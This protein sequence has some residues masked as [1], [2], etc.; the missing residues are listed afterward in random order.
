MDW[1]FKKREQSQLTNIRNE[2]G[3]PADTIRI[4]RKYYKQLHANSFEILY[5][6]DKSLEKAPLPK[7]IQEGIARNILNKIYA[8]VLA[9]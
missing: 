7:L 5:K 2:K 6:I 4:I 8:M 3:D 1:F 9:I